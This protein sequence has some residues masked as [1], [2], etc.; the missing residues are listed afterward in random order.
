MLPMT[1]EW[2][3]KA[4][5]DYDVVLLLLR[6]R[7]RSR[8]DP[9]CFHAQQCAEKY[10]KARLTESAIAFTKTHDLPILLTLA[11]AVVP[12]WSVVQNRLK[13]LTN[14]AVLARYPGTAAT[15]SDAR[16]A[17]ATCRR[18]RVLARRSLGLPV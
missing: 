18:L 1:R 3:Q 9:I 11:V 17:V 6:S 12:N 10:L 5:G 16:E 4:E 14:W 7:K 8:F 15:A 13:V 2:V